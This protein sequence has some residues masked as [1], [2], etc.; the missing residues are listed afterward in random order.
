MSPCKNHREIEY[1]FFGELGVIFGV[2]FIRVLGISGC[3]S[4]FDRF[5][6]LLNFTELQRKNEWLVLAREMGVL[7]FGPQ[8]GEIQRGATLNHW[9]LFSPLVREGTPGL[10]FA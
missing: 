9:F 8:D 5:M 4:A 10:R 6:A 7:S 3:G 2:V 1:T